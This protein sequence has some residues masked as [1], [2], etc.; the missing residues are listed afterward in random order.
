M[1]AP[2]R[3]ETLELQ[4]LLTSAQDVLRTERRRTV[5]EQQAYESFGRRL[6]TIAPDGVKATTERTTLLEPV[7]TKGLKRVREAFEATVMSVPHFGEEYGEPYE[8]CLAGEFSPE[9]AAALTSR[10]HLDGDCKQTV[11]ESVAVAQRARDEFLDSIDAETASLEGAAEV[12]IPIREELADFDTETLINGGF[13]SV[14]AGIARLGVVE[15]TCETVAKRRQ[16]TIDAQRSRLYDDPEIL[17]VPTY[18]YQELP[19]T[20]PVLWSVAEL[21]TEIEAKRRAL[22][23]AAG[24]CQ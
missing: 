11:V 17:D 2:D 18:V 3:S 15:E 16:R 12:L 22:E 13:G 20:Y 19:V 8:A 24:E 10:G 1:P 5:D 7:E 9:I 6:R 14:E 4:P 21:G 23:R